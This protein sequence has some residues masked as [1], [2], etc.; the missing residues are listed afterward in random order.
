MGV[1]KMGEECN[2]DLTYVITLIKN[3]IENNKFISVSKKVLKLFDTNPWDF[4][5]YCRQ[6]LND[7]SERGI[8]NALSN[9]K[10]AIEC[11]VDE[12]LALIN[13]TYFASKHR[14]GLPYKLQVIKTFGISAP[15]VLISYITSRRNILEHEY[16]KP[17]DIEEIKYIADITELFLSASNSIINNGYITSVEFENEKRFEKKPIDKYKVQFINYED[18]YLISFDLKKE[19]I[20]LTH[21]LFEL[22]SELNKRTTALT[23][24]GN[25]KINKENSSISFHECKETEI[26]E[27]MQLIINYHEE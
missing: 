12:I 14:W 5:S 18:K 24:R 23:S 9:A 3:A 26:K 13:L 10:R 22:H 6:D 20:T 11:R 17:K 27:L 16:I 2:L 1:K 7:D 19:T 8:A 4:L 21:E 15:D 25:P